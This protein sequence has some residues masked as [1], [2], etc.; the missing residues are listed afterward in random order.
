MNIIKCHILL[1][2][3]FE[4]LL[5][6]YDIDYTTNDTSLGVNIS[7]TEKVYPGDYIEYSIQDNDILFVRNFLPFQPYEN[8]QVE[9][10]LST[11]GYRDSKI[12]R[13]SI[14]NNTLLVKYYYN[15]L[16]KERDV[17]INYAIHKRDYT[18]LLP[19][20]LKV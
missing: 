13:I 12:S 14:Q 3:I 16:G 17:I 9:N 18:G 7:D 10:T 8:L 5:E 2:P 11:K 6:K 19:I 15:V 1:Y 4:F 20:K